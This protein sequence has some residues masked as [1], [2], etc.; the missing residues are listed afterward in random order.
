MSGFLTNGMNQL[1]LSLDGN[2]RLPLDTQLTAGSLPESGAMN[3]LQ[4]AIALNYLGQFLAAGKTMVAGTRYYASFPV[5]TAV[6]A[7]GIAILVGGTGGTDRWT[8]ELFNAAG[9]LVATSDF[10]TGIIAGTAAVWQRFPFGVTGS[11]AAVNIPVGNYFISVQSNGTTAKFSA[12][13]APTA[14][15]G[16]V[17]GSA[18]GVFSTQAAITPPTTY[19][20]NLGPI[21]TL[22][23]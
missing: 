5:G 14:P 7:T 20:A 1:V 19:T 23:Q 2:S 12:F 4:M 13:N 22:Y 3:L 21:A 11:E 8:V 9:V 18:A 6:Q 10:A 15:A 16:L 17:T